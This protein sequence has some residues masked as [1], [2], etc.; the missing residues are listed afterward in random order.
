MKW[1]VFLFVFSLHLGFTLEYRRVA[2]KHTA[3]VTTHQK[4]I[5]KLKRNNAYLNRLIEK[6]LIEN[7]GGI[8]NLQGYYF[9]CQ[10]TYLGVNDFQVFLGDSLDDT[11]S[12]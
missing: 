12:K 3:F 11:S 8:W 9:L 5:A 7:S 6:C 10:A 1:I 2:L 4:V